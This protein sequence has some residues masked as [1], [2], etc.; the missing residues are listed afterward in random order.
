M[1]TKNR[2]CF[3]IWERNREEALRWEWDLAV[4]GEAEILFSSKA[5]MAK[6]FG[7]GTDFP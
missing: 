2:F 6:I 4:E 1:L 7:G 5:P 3:K